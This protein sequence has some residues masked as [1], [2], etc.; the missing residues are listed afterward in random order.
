MKSSASESTN[1]T[2]LVPKEQSNNNH[3]SPDLVVAVENEGPSRAVKK[4]EHHRNLS[5]GGSG[6]R[7]YPTVQDPVLPP[8][9][10]RLDLTASMK[11]PPR[12]DL[13]LSGEHDDADTV[14]GDGE[15]DRVVSRDVTA[16]PESP[17]ESKK[18][19]KGTDIIPEEEE[20]FSK[21]L[22]MSTTFR[23]ELLN[24]IRLDTESRVGV[25]VAKLS[26]PHVDVIQLLGVNLPLICPYIDVLKKEV[27]SGHPNVGV[28]APLK[29]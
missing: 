8:S 28:W 23:Q 22:T 9:N 21:R 24:S 18:Q 13:T 6:L 12:P 19:S 17:V 7:S 25:E 1:Q 29:F 26:D 5:D 14:V 2:N 27:R 20:E 15:E 16:S 11:G 10:V 4:T 3:S